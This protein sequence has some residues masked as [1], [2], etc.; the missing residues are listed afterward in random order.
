MPTRRWRTV[1]TII[2]HTTVAFGSVLASDNP[3]YPGAL[4]FVIF[5]FF[6]DG[7]PRLNRWL[8]PLLVV[9]LA[10]LHSRCQEAAALAIPPVSHPI[11]SPEVSS[12]EQK[13][14]DRMTPEF[15]AR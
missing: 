10:L 7:V 2:G 5:L 1:L 9:A 14:W 13:M 6:V 8:S 11:S 12:F 15:N 3:W 4:F